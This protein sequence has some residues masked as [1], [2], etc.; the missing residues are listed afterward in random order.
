MI[1]GG[2]AGGG[3]TFGTLL[4]LLDLCRYPNFKGVI[5]R[6]IG[7]NITGGGGLWDE[8]HKLFPHLGG[9]PMQSAKKWV[10][11]SGASVTFR[12]LEHEK[13]ADAHQG[14]QYSFI[15]FDEL[16]HFTEGQFWKLVSRLRGADAGHEPILRAT[17]NPDPDSFVAKLVSWWIDQ[18]TGFAISRRSGVVRFF[19][20]NP[21]N[22]ELI[23]GAT[24]RQLTDLFP[25]CEPKSLTFILSTLEDNR[26]LMVGD[27]SYRASLMALP[28]VERERL[29]KGNWKIRANAG[30]V[31]RREWFPFID[32]APADARKIRYWDRAATEVSPQNPDPDWTAGVKIS[33][34]GQGVYYVED[35]C[36]GRW[37]PN[38]VK[39]RIH[40][41]ASQ[42]GQACMVGIERDPGSAGV[43]EADDLVRSLAEFRPRLFTPSG[44]KVTRA[45]PA[46][47][48]A[49]AG[50]VRIVRGPWN[51]AFLAELENFPTGGHDDQVDGLSG[52]LNALAQRRS[53]MLA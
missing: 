47:S 30:T 31:F 39:Q 20:R 6:R 38:K 29:L 21:A 53:I 28:K 11:P 3:K 42:D 25:A 7:A 9:R 19:I 52:G 34:D 32:V 37:T 13:S 46:S 10:F 5:F 33:R 48:Q 18:E 12:H 49:E 36:R 24:K 44:D 40:A 26:A 2:A 15:A 51:D 16:T 23:W 50:N 45:G 4:H 27:P 41:V 35:V 17:C 1:Y 22:D 14:L 43:A 8:S